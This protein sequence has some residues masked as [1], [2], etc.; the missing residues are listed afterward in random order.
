MKRDACVLW[1]IFSL[2]LFYTRQLNTEDKEGWTTF[3]QGLII[4][5]FLILW[6]EIDKIMKVVAVC[7]QWLIDQIEANENNF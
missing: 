3:T 7:L 5:G 1:Y 2:T 4:S 6:D